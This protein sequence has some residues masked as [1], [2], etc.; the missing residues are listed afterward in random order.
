MQRRGWVC[1][2]GNRSHAGSQPG[3][4]YT[5]VN[6]VCCWCYSVWAAIVPLDRWQMGSHSGHYAGHRGHEVHRVTRVTKVTRVTRVTGVIFEHA[7][8]RPGTILEVTEGSHRATRGCQRT[9][10]DSQRGA[11]GI[12]LAVQVFN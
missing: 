9:S 10:P 11:I 12:F 7:V 4:G 3:S 2:G 5:R 6:T 1:L 8:S